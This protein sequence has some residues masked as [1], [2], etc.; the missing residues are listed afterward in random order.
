M[1]S[2]TDFISSLEKELEHLNKVPTLKSTVLHKIRHAGFSIATDI[3]NLKLF[4]IIGCPIYKDGK[5]VAVLNLNR[6]TI[7]LTIVEGSG[8]T[9]DA[10]SKILDRV[11]EDFNM[12]RT[13]TGENMLVYTRKLPSKEHSLAKSNFLRH[14]EIQVGSIMIAQGISRPEK[15]FMEVTSRTNARIVLKNISS[16]EGKKLPYGGFVIYPNK[17][18]F[19]DNQE[20]KSILPIGNHEPFY[21]M[22]DSGN[23]VLTPLKGESTENY[24]NL[25]F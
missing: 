15:W 7:S 11:R 18:S 10:F 2:Y 1:I 9:V 20:H 8:Y 5:A 14:P 6:K 21:C 16:K 19:V 3:P 12:E 13:M 24:P 22:T 23:V 17:G 25:E 4:G